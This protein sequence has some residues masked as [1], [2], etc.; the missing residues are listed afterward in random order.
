M[1]RATNTLLSVRTAVGTASCLAPRTAGRAFGLDASANPQ[2]PYLARLFGVRD[3]ALAVGVLTAA[4]SA[5]RHWLTV[6]LACDLA[7]VV[8]GIAG[9]KA[10]YLSRAS[11][12]LVTGAAISAVVLGA[13]ALQEAETSND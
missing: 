4:P 6:G 5:R 8:S 2:S 12:V 10:G 11:G 7:D 9:T 1:S 3:L 13:V